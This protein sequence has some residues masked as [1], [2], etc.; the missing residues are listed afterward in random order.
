M[1]FFHRF[2]KLWTSQKSAILDTYL[3][4]VV[5]EIITCYLKMREKLYFENARPLPAVRAEQKG[6]KVEHN[7]YK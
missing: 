5:S 4:S 6:L 7:A 2:V 1:K 3:S